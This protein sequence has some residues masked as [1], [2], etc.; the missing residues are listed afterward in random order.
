ML[1]RQPR[2]QRWTA[3]SSARPNPEPLPLH[4]SNRTE[5]P[6]LSET[7]LPFRWI[8]TTLLR[9]RLFVPTVCDNFADSSSFRLLI[10]G[11]VSSAAKITVWRSAPL[12]PFPL[13]FHVIVSRRGRGRQV[14][15][16]DGL[17]PVTSRWNAHPA[18]TFLCMASTYF[19]VV[20]RPVGL[21]DSGS[22][23]TREAKSAFKQP[24]RGLS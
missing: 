11:Y 21:A 23:A 9:G 8:A 20:S 1:S 10:Q 13:T 19:R 6:M 3:A 2:D 15:H 18:T 5:T 4:R 22:L 17:C 14:D 16:I 7:C 12:I 24:A